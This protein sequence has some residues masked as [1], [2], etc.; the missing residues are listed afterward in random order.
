MRCAPIASRAGRR[1][2]RRGLALSQ[3]APTPAPQPRRRRRSAQR[4]A[5]AA[6]L[7]RR[8]RAGASRRRR[9]A[10]H[11]VRRLRGRRR[12]P[13]RSRRQR[14]AQAL[15]RGALV[16]RLL[17]SL[18]DIPPRRAPRRRADYLARAGSDF[19]ADEQRQH[20][21][22]KSCAVLDDPRFAD[23][24]RPDSRAEV[25]IVGRIVRGRS[26]PLSGRRPGRPPGGYADAV[27]IADY[28]TNRPAPRAN[29]RCAAQ[30]T[31]AAR[32]V[33]RGA[34][35]ALSRTEPSGPRWSGPMCLI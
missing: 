8:R 13:R 34:S 24:S 3:G 32:A 25:P 30:P 17:Q 14:D 9:V 15:A 11:A 4:P 2:R 29:R 5:R 6:D 35:Q 16:H 7:A 33:P 28:K 18:P 26:P 12:R 22:S 21:S 31:R 27:L 23:C 20:C 1:R 10:A 19:A